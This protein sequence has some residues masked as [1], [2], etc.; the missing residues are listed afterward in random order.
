[1]TSYAHSINEIKV[2][3]FAMNSIKKNKSKQVTTQCFKAGKNLTHHCG[4]GPINCRRWQR[5]G[6]KKIRGGAQELSAAAAAAEARRDC[7][8]L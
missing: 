1:M 8:Q 4:I 6:N 5:T 7:T 3:A 2:V